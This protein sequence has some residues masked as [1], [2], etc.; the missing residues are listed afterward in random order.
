MLVEPSKRDA[1]QWENKGKK[2][3]GFGRVA[4]ETELLE[5]PVIKKA[6]GCNSIRSR[7][8]G[9]IYHEDRTGG[10]MMIIASNMASHQSMNR[11]TE[12][13]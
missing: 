1:N 12:N 9:I 8:T 2:M 6:E 10:G 13:H 11:K 3:A 5:S 7:E 4:S